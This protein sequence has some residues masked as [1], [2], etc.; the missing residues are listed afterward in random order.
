MTLFTPGWARGLFF[1]L[2]SIQLVFCKPDEEI[3]VPM[4]QP[5]EISL[6]KTDEPIPMEPMI[7]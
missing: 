4:A 1:F 3:K 7:R 5:L 2:L 6:E